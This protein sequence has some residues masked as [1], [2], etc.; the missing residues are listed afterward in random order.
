M[1]E[2]PVITAVIPF[3]D[4]AVGNARVVHEAGV[5]TFSICINQE[6]S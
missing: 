3:L 5:V 1:D 4:L 6:T 2:H